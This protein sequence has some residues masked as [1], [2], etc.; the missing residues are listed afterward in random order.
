MK[1]SMVRDRISGKGLPQIETAVSVLLMNRERRNEGIRI[2]LA[3][4]IV[5]IMLLAILLASVRLGSIHMDFKTILHGIFSDKDEQFNTVWDLRF[6]RIIVAL[7]GGAS[8]AVSGVLFQAVLKNPLADP[9]LIGI[10]SASTFTAAV[11][12]HFFPMLFSWIPLFCFVAGELSFFLVYS[13]SWKHGLSPLRILLVGIAVQAVFT[14]L[15]QALTAMTGAAR[16]GAAAIVNGNISMK[17]WTDVNCLLFYLI[18]GLLLALFASRYC[19]ILAFQDK[20]V[21]S[22]GIEVNMLRFL[23]SLVAVLLAASVSAVVGVIGFLGLLVPHIGRIIVGNR[24]KILI[25]FTM[26]LGAVLLLSADTAGR[27]LVYP[28]EISPGVIMSLLGGPVFIF[29]LRRSETLSER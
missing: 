23:I 24:H 27:L 29:L 2:A 6:P 10:S 21:R 16:S 1:F 12:M 3:F 13:L 7:L 4:L 15:F 26:L 11:I 25:P 5:T 28:Y 20:T 18:P 9:G 19:D 17:T 22:L 8:M 14:G